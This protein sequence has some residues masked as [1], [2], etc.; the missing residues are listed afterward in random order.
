MLTIPGYS[1][2]RQIHDGRRSL[3]FQGT[4]EIDNLPVIIKTLKNKFPSLAESL[5]F[6]QEYSILQNAGSHGIVRAYAMETIQ[7]VSMIIMEDF[8]GISLDKSPH[9]EKLSLPE[10][11]TLFIRIPGILDEI[12]HQSIVHKDINSTNIVWNPDTGQVKV[13]DF[14]ISSKISKG[15]TD[16]LSADEFQG[17]VAYISPEQTGR[18]NRSLDFRT[19]LYSLGVTFYELLTRQRPFTASDSMELVYAHFAKTPVPPGDIKSDIPKVLSNIILKLLAKMPEHRYQS[20]IGLKADLETCL[21]NLETDGTIKFFKIGQK[22]I[23]DQF[24]ISQKLYNRGNDIQSLL[25]VYDRI[26]L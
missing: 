1:I 14:G 7:N 21:A 2:A 24:C 9:I 15:K 23:S 3:I 6:Q 25:V 18:M 4:R 13:I 17:T 22:D 11:L 5:G 10:L 19:D 20:A 12:H 16:L 26:S 8:G